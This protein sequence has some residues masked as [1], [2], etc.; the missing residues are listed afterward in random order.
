MINW[1][2]HLYPY[3]NFHELNLDWV[4]ATLKHGENDIKNFI[5]ANVI[6]YADPIAWDI[7]RQYE[8]NTVVVDPGTG[9]A[10]IS[11]KPVP[12]GYDLSH[13]E[14]WTKVFSY[15][16]VVDT[17]I[18]QIATNEGNSVTAHRDYTTGELLFINGLLYETLVPIVTGGA[19]VSGTNINAITVEQFINT[20]IIAVTNYVDSEVA[21]INSKITD[22]NTTTGLI[23]GDSFCVAGVQQQIAALFRISN[24]YYYGNT[25]SGYVRYVSAGQPYGG[26]T[27]EELADAAYI[28]MGSDNAN[29]LDIV[30]IYGGINDG[31][32][33]ISLA[34]LATASLSCFNKVKTLFPNAEIV[35]ACNGG[36]LA[37][38]TEYQDKIT[39]ILG[40]AASVGCIALNNIEHVLY[41]MTNIVDTDN[42]H[43]TPNG[44]RVIAY[45]LYNAYKG[46]DAMNHVYHYDATGDY[47]GHVVVH[48]TGGNVNVTIDLTCVNANNDTGITL[49]ERGVPGYVIAC[50]CGN[51]VGGTFFHITTGGKLYIF[52]TTSATTRY[53]A[54]VSYP[55]GIKTT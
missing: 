39:S 19:F 22:I 50:A 28:E 40:N 37:L 41:N 48:T 36:K 32:N 3:T 55:V 1:F 14:Y 54:T 24:P 29:K 46:S 53:A 6:K 17:L 16:G 15:G 51:N 31:G 38:S 44:C 13:I 35:V 12:F 45:N 20:K 23:I 9:D 4:L 25:G 34:D 52:G 43:P 18:S 5:G 8:G 11:V 27:F 47:T 10:Y 2:D 7:S 21:T 49:L 42:I 33:D 30:I 26:K